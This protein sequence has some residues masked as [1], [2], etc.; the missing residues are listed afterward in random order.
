MQLKNRLVKAHEQDRIL[1]HRRRWKLQMLVVGLEVSWTKIQDF[2]DLLGEPVRFLR[3]CSE[4]TEVTESFTNLGSVVHNIE[5]SDQEVSRRIGL[6]AGAM[7]SLD[8]NIWRCRYLCRRTELRVFKALIMP[9]LLYGSETC[10][11]SYNLKPH[12]DAICNRSLCR[13]MEYYWRDHV[14]NQWSHLQSGTRP[15]TCTIRDR[16]LRL[17][18]YLARSPQQDD[19]A[20][21]GVSV[22]D[23]PGWRRPVR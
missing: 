21:R 17:Y 1:S 23:N 19:P 8:K 7:N 2:G 4:E 13:I 18:G 12:L 5:L 22:R 9:V 20:H 6:A 15:F 3:A 16:Q 14:F 11:L 10:T